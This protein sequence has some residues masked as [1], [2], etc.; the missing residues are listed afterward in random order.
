MFSSIDSLPEKLQA[1]LEESWAGSFY[2]EYF[3]RID[4]DP[5]AVLYSDEPSRPN[6]PVNV[7]VGLDTLKSGFGWSDA[8]MY[9]HWC[10]DVQ[11]RYA[12]GYR[13]LREGHF[14]LRT[15]YNFRQRVTK[16]MRETGK[17]LYDEAFE[18]VSDEQVAAFGLK[19]DRLRVDSTLIASNIR[20][21]TRLQL[22]VEVVQRVHRM[23]DEADRERYAEALESYLRGSSGQYI[24][25]LKGKDVAEHLQAIGELMHRLVG[26]LAP[27]YGEEPTYQVLQRVFREHF[28]VDESALRPKEGQELSASSLQSP[29][30]WEATYRRKRGE[31]HRGYTT[32]V[33]ETCHPENDLQLIVK[34][35]T[36]PNNTDDAAM[37]DEALPGLK[38]RTDVE[39]MYSDGGYNSPQVDATMREQGVEQVQ[40]AI[41]GRKPAED[42]P[43]L[44]DFHWETNADGEPQIVTCPHGQRSTVGP[45][46]KA[47]RYRASFDAPACASCPFCDQC[48]TQPLKRTPERVLRFSQQE[49]DLALRRQRSAAARTKRQNL[50]TAVEATVRSVKHPFGNGKVPVRGQPRVSMVVVGSAAMSNVR[51]IHRYQV[52]Q[53]KAEE[54]GQ[55][56]LTGT[57]SDHRVPAA[58]L[59]ASFL[60]QLRSSLHS[61][62]MSRPAWT[63]G[64]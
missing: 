55:T 41:R 7:L 50:R 28:V 12:L 60:T 13:D 38:E 42:K 33:T 59:F 26:E 27:Q 16:H 34:V 30:D 1:R 25:H 56:H 46:R 3:V 24:Y 61:L 17:N 21:T 44:D 19:T 35:Q 8:E 62:S 52:A 11:V 29:D 49:V 40:S 9:D 20:E 51:R 64:F 36:E 45:G 14:E 22:L 31:D 39:Q 58:S 63:Y 48:P 47:N 57:R 5:F 43:G 37:L 53:R 23:L 4:E 32:N 54:A 15:L 18:Q 6:I 2:R 10:Y